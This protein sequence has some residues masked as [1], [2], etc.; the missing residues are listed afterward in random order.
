MWKLRLLGS[1]AVLGTVLGRHVAQTGE[2]CDQIESPFVN[3]RAES[4]PDACLA[5]DTARNAILNVM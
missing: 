3:G 5:L 4:M 1:V 2:R